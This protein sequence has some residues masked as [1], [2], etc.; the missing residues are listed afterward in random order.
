MVNPTFDEI[1]KAKLYLVVA[2]TA[3]A[4]AMVEGEAK[5]ASEDEMIEAIV[6]AHKAMQPIVALQN[7]LVKK[8]GKAKQPIERKA[9]DKDLYYKVI[10]LSVDAMA[11]AV[12]VKT[13]QARYKAVEAVKDSVKAQ[14]IEQDA[15][16]AE[17]QSEISAYLEE[18]Q[19]SIVRTQIIEE[20]VRIDGRRLDEV[21]KITCEVGVLP[22]VHGSAL[23]TRG[24][25]QSLATVT[26]GS[27]RDEQHIDDLT[28]DI[29]VP[30]MLHYNF[31]PFSVG[32]VKRIG[33]T[34]RRE[35]GHGNLATRG[36]EPILPSKED[37]NYTMRIVS[38]ILESN[39]SSSMATVCAS[40]LALMNA[41]VPVKSDVAGIAMG[42]IQEGDKIAILSDILGDEDHLGD[43]DFKVVGTEKGINA[44]Q[45][46]IKIKGLSRK[47]LEDALAQ[48]HRGRMHILG[49]MRKAIRKPAAELSPYAPRIIT[50]HINPDKIRDLIGPGGKMIRGITEQTGCAIDVEDSG[51]VTISSPDNAAAKR[52]MD[53]INGLTQEAQVGRIYYGTVRK[54]MDFGAF[55]EILPGTDGLVPISELDEDHVERVEDVVSEGDEIKVKCINID[56]QGKI[57]LSR[58]QAL[59][60][61]DD[62]L[63]D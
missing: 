2:S 50:T 19:R 53:I 20:G 16:L 12:N 8:A 29:Y 7:Q 57:R 40:S 21:R 52:A 46:D 25:T 61:E 47:I 23:F 34:G 1:P 3:D 11:D 28:G 43:M 58:K 26:L 33:S 5:E 42:L 62:D 63:D 18:V 56:R 54:I 37:F 31:P 48:A 41:G 10:D 24:E 13:K 6:T 30:F 35:L 22:R 55:V 32:E 27:K 17:R 45:M 59:L 15:S 39:G 51:K 14:L 44:L 9:I 49:E 60:E 36:V 38:E 4:I